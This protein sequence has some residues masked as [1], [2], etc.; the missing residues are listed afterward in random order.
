MIRAGVDAGG[1]NMAPPGYSI[2]T[3]DQFVGQELGVSS[4]FA[5][6]QDQIG[7]LFWLRSSALWFFGILMFAACAAK[8]ADR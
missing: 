6:G 1:R 2:A 8:S 7:R 4:W 5:V 3:L